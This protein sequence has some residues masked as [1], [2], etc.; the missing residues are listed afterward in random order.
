MKAA[1]PLAFV[2][3]L[4]IGACATTEEYQYLGRLLVKNDQGHVVGHTDR[5][6]DSSG[7]SFEQTTYYTPRYDA[8][9][10]IVGYE[11]PAMRGVAL[12]DVNGKRTGMRFSDLRSRGTNPSN[13]GVTV[14]VAPAGAAAAGGR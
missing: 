14:I 9:G 2:S 1:V 4:V 3:L 10:E 6:R 7:E 12:R 11:E 5:L 13:E 8:K